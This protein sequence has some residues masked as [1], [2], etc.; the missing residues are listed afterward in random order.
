MAVV[1]SR[2]SVMTLFS[3]PT[4]IHSHRTRLVLAEKNIN[5]EIANIPGP[6]LP[7]DLMDLNPYHSVPT[8]VDRDLTLYDSRVIIEYLDERFPH[9]PLM[10]VD[11]VTRAQF[12]LALYR[13]ENDWYKI[14]EEAESSGDGKLG[15]KSRKMLRE[16]ILQSAELFQARPYFLS[17]EFS[18]VDC[19]IAPLLWRLPVY[20]V[21]LGSG[22]GAIEAYMK[23]VFA[24]R[25]FRKSLTELEQEM[26]P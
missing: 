16:S 4:D 3:R 8:L 21:E 15:T 5:I 13:I 22:A 9:P 23:R 18:L 20:G 7:E 1:A 17:D 14:A 24:R 19:T 26:R 6:D 25:S 11:P 10:P 2:R 12:R